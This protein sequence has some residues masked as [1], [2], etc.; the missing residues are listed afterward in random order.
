MGNEIVGERRGKY[1]FD[2]NGIYRRGGSTRVRLEL[3]IQRSVGGDNGG[4][5]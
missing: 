4:W 3:A 2:V 1:V 5:R